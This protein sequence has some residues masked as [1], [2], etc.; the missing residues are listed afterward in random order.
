MES[1]WSGCF[2]IYWWRDSSWGH[3]RERVCRSRLWGS[4]KNKL[5]TE[6]RASPGN[7]KRKNSVSQRRFT[8]VGEER[9]KDSTAKSRKENISNGN[10]GSAVSAM[11][12]PKEVRTE[13][14]T[15]YA[16]LQ[17][18]PSSRR[19]GTQAIPLEWHRVDFMPAEEKELCKKLPPIFLPYPIKRD[20]KARSS[21][22]QAVLR[23]LC[24]LM[25]LQAKVALNPKGTVNSCTSLTSMGR[26]KTEVQT[27]P[28]FLFFSQSFYRLFSAFLL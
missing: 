20:V 28:G 23:A 15:G 16:D 27:Y 6:E 26:R 1:G 9:C 3:R 25:R 19:E 2:V 13:S 17:K 22:V 7:V 14:W 12:E 10:S 5:E 4:N 21:L 18:V 8:K 24:C 11:E